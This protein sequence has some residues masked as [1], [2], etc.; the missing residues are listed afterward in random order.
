VSII[1]NAGGRGRE[2]AEGN[3]SGENSGRKRYES[4]EEL[5]GFYHAAFLFHSAVCDKIK[6][7]ATK[8]LSAGQALALVDINRGL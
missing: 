6:P 2:R 5:T 7:P 1:E 4:A 3:K 8:V